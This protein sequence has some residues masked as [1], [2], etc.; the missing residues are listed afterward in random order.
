MKR[1]KETYVFQFA[2]HPRTW[3][4]T[5]MV[6][7]GIGAI[8]ASMLDLS[9]TP[10]P[11]AQASLDGLTKNQVIAF[12]GG[13]PERCVYSRPD[14]Q[15]CTWKLDGTLITPGSD[16]AKDGVNLVCEL[17]IGA[18]ADFEGSCTPHA[19]VSASDLPPVSAGETPNAAPES[20]LPGIPVPELDDAP[21]LIDLS[22]RLG[23]APDVCRTGFQQ[24]TC[25]WKLPAESVART[26]AGAPMAGPLELRC[27]L[28][29]ED[30]ARAPGSCT[31][32]PL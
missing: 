17:P 1:Q 3:I 11:A 15:L 19:R 30:S 31:T 9:P 29:L 23:A 2:A 18:N 27:T 20:E 5:A 7:A 12:A 25:I 14:R 16:P 4:I 10:A 6:A 32:T 28:P 8:T 13:P 22:Q 21:L 24:Q 26:F